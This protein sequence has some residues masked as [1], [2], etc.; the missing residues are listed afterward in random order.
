MDGH[1]R[2][3]VVLYRDMIFLPLMKN[4]EDKMTRYD[5]N[6]LAIPPALEPGERRIIAQFHDECCFHA[7]DE[8]SHAWYFPLLIT[9]CRID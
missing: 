2:H 4:F 6:G 7:N 8:S 9:A 3:D 5:V 1:E